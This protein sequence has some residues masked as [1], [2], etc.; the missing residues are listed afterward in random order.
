MSKSLTVSSEHTKKA[1]AKKN[2]IINLLWNR[3]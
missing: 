2:H 3:D 1:L